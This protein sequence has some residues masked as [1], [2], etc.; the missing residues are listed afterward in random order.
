M[1]GAV[2]VIMISTIIERGNAGRRQVVPRG[3]AAALSPAGKADLLRTWRHER[4]SP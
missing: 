4:R 3:T 2:F 1:G